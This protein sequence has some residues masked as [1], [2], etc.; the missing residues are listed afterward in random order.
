MRLSDYFGNA[1]MMCFDRRVA[2]WPQVE[3]GFATIGIRPSRFIMGEGTNSCLAYDWV[4]RFKGD[5]PG[6]QRLNYCEAVQSL[7]CREL[8]RG[9]NHVFIAEDDCAAHANTLETF[10]AVEDQLGPLDLSFDVF[11]LHAV[12]I[13]G[14]YQHVSANVLKMDRVLGFRALILNRKAME[15]IVSLHASTDRGID[16]HFEQRQDDLLVYSAYPCLFRG[17]AD[18]YSYQHE[19]VVLPEWLDMCLAEKGKPL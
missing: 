10:R 4:D 14:R 11:Y 15:R 1:H 13:H 3:R 16:G 2:I 6:R 18:H 17:D 12:R 8:E 19:M 7:L 9:A 5:L